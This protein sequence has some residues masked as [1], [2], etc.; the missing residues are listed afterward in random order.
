[1]KNFTDPNMDC[2]V[3]TL[4]LEGTLVLGGGKNSPSSKV[5]NFYLALK[6]WA[7]TSDYKHYLYVSH[8]TFT[9]YN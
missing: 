8:E 2:K 7:A 5:D 1:M 3:F 4:V 6:S 9:Y